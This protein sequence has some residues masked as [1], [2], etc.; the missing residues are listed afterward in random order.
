VHIAATAPAGAMLT[1]SA[2]IAGDQAEINLAN[3]S[4]TMRSTVTRATDVAVTVT[5]DA[6]VV[7]PGGLDG[8]TVTVTNRGPLVAH[9]VQL[10]DVLP[11]QLTNPGDPP[12][13][14][15]TGNTAVCALGTMAVN[16]SMTT[17]FSGT[18]PPSIPAGT[19]LV[20]TATVTLAE[21]DSTPANNTATAPTVVVAASVATSVPPASAI[22][23]AA[24]AAQTSSPSGPLPF[25]GDDVVLWLRASLVL[26]TL[27]TGLGLAGRRTR[28]RHRNVR[29]R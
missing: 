22:S 15:F 1:Q 14:T 5:A 17:H 16:A 2:H 29:G 18:V 21:T 10:A 13:C 7:N 27:G 4:A 9:A 25:T 26:I 20:D 19:R 28:R 23:T 8:Y 24:P 6:A 12:A 11:S 3:N